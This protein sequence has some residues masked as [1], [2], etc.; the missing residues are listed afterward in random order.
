MNWWGR[1]GGLSLILLVVLFSCEED[2]P[3][4]GIKNPE[5]KFRV[6]YAE[7]N[8]PSSVVLFKDLV[9][10][11]NLNSEPTIEDGNQR[12]LVGEYTDDIFGKIRTE[13]YTQIGPPVL[14]AAISSATVYDSLVLQLKTDF[15]QYGSSSISEERIEVYELLDTVNSGRY[16]NSTPLAYS[17]TSIGGVSFTVN[18][19]DYN[20]AITDNSDAVTTNNRVTTFRMVLRGN[21]GLSLYETVKSETDL[22]SDYAKFTGLYKGL[23]IV[24]AGNGNKVIG[25]NPVIPDDGFPLATD[26]KLILYYSEGGTQKSIDFVLIP[27]SNPLTRTG[28]PVVGYSSIIA[29]RSGTSL[30]GL[31]EPHQDYYPIDDKRVTESGIGILTKLDFTEYF[32]YMDTVENAVLNSAE[33]VIEGEQSEFAFPPQFQLRAMTDKNF[34]QSWITQDTTIGGVFTRFV[35]TETLSIFWASGAVQKNDNGT[36]DLLADNNKDVA[37]LSANQSFVISSYLTQFFQVQYGARKSS[38][39]M[40]YVALVPRISQFNKTVNRSVLKNNIK[41][42]MY[43]TSPIPEKE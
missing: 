35:D 1:L 3:T 37:Y 26:T 11:N 17:R 36:L 10:Y 38:K 27:H 12:L 9:T 16:F 39:R 41:L 7:I 40:N 4:I 23:A 33:L 14:N 28:Y 30:S 21:L 34:F 18:P 24:P 32:N 25:I 8:I 43:Y 13:T 2:V 15:Y 31:T 22:K 42:K 19:A 6:N 5:S 20:Q 29:D